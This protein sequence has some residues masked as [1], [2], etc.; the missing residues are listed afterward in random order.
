MPLEVAPPA[1]PKA[2]PAKQSMPTTHNAIFIEFVSY[3]EESR[4]KVRGDGLEFLPVFTSPGQYASPV[5]NLAGAISR[6][7]SGSC[8]MRC[9]CLHNGGDRQ[10][11]MPCWEPLSLA[12]RSTGL[13]WEGPRD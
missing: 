13:E 4:I 11:G 1:C 3:L 6:L 7:S 10:H 9:N 2:I 12:V 8:R 5:P